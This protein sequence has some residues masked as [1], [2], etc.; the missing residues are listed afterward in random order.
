MKVCFAKIE[1]NHIA[2]LFFDQ[3][4]ILSFLPLAN[5]VSATSY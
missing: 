1:I 2:L 3:S 5:P 4:K